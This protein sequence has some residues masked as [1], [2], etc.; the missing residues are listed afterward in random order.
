VATEA[1]REAWDAWVAGLP[2]ADPLQAWDWGTV[3]ATGHERPVRLMATDEAGRVGGVAQVLVRE[4]LAGRRVLYVPHG[5][6]WAVDSAD[7]RAVLAAL[8]G[9]LRD[10]G[11]AERGIVLK[12]DP[13]ATPGV[14]AEEIRSQLLGQGARPARADL[15]ATTTR[16]IDLCPGP[17]QLFAR[18]EKDTRNL[19]RRSAREG[20]RP[21]V[22]RGSDPDAYSVFAD[23]LAATGQ[24]AGFRVR[25]RAAFEAIS[26]SFAARGEACLVLAELAGR[27]I[28]GCLALIVGGRAYYLYAAS[29]RAPELRHAAGPYAALWACIEALAADGRESLDLWGVAEPGDRAADPTWSGFSL[30]KRGFGGVRLRHPGTFD[31]VLAP[32]WYAIRDLRERLGRRL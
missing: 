28:A 15:Q 17:E 12:L 16:V 10:L 29:V 19:V 31:L 20:V 24:R 9:A 13:R 32:G 25:P 21:R 22:V 5:P 23:L 3:A 2:S 27:P 14:P 18:L 30:F 11:R 1:D 26:A 4:A 6:L 7:G 8:V